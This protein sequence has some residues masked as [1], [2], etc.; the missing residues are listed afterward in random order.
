M[1][2]LWHAGLYNISPQYLINGKIF[3]K[4]L[5][6]MKCVSR[7]SLQRL[8]ETFLVLRRTERDMM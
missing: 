3:G 8:S 5:L 7:F 4:T 1:R 6:N 2:H